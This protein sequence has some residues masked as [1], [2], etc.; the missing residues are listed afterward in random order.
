MEDYRIKIAELDFKKLQDLVFADMPKEAGAFALA[1]AA[2]HK[3]GTDIIVRRPIQIPKELFSLQQEFHFEVSPKAINGL[4]ALCQ[5][6]GLGAVLC[7]SHPTDISYSPS[8]DYGERRI[9]EVLQQFI[10]WNAPMASLLFCPGGVRSRVWLSGS[11]RPK[12]ISEVIIVGRYL[13]RIRPDASPADENDFYKEVFDRQVRAFGKDGQALILRTKVGIVGT[14]GTGSAIAEQLIRLGTRDIVLIDHD[15]FHPSNITRMYGTFASFSRKRWRP[16]GKKDYKKVALLAAHVTKINPNIK[17]QAIPINVVL[18]DAAKRLLDRDIIF[19]CTDDHWGRSIINQTAYQ[20]FIPT[21]NLGMRI[22]A[23]DG[24]ISEGV[25]IVDVLRPDL[26]CLWCRQYLRAERIAAESMP[27]S[28]RPSL[29]R[30]GYVE[31]I[32]TPAPS[33]VSITTT[34]SGLAVTLFIQLITDFQGNNGNIERLNYDIMEG[35]VRRGK[36]TIINECLC[37]K[38]RGF[39]DL[40][41]LNTMTE[42]GFL[43]N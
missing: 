9:F 27:R 2:K 16:F 10:P 23:K 12:F 37:K 24:K 40:K 15:E 19:L 41:T 22:A 4:I 30:E 39:G 42:I 32:E 14:G 5:K 3:G 11:L 13:N 28:A 33:V 43:D 38:V 1:G 7:H 25:G 8:D 34:L 29:E 20:Y 21:I 17:I 26:P 31:D 6:N 18:Q 35:T 36:S